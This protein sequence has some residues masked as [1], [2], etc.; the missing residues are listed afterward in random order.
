MLII[1]AFV[2]LVFLPYPWNLVAFGVGLVL[3]TGE[4]FFWN[5]TVKGR[6]RQVGAETLI[7]REGV[8]LSPCSPNGQVKIGG[9]IW[10]AHCLGG[11]RTGDAVRV[12]GLDG[13]SL[14][15]ERTTS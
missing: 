8:A 7:G 5:R 2:L 3:G 14:L 10:E 15:V 12:I 6:R 11:A 13:L 4:L 9:E 1:V